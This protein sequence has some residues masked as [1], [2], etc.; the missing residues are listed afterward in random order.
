MLGFFGLPGG[1]EWLLI[2]FA[3]LLIFHRRIPETLRGI[4][5]G[6]RQFKRAWNK[7]HGDSDEDDEQDQIE[8]GPRDENSA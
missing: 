5:D 6:V 2:L 7:H 3:L 1:G 4:G 8:D